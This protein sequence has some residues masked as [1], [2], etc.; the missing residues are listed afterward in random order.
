MFNWWKK[1]YRGRKL[2]DVDE[3]NEEKKKLAVNLGGKNGPDPVVERVG[4][5]KR[6]WHIVEGKNYGQ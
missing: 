6:R 5:I 3:P 2:L 4:Q 1:S